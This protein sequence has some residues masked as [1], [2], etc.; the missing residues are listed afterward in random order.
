MIKTFKEIF[1]HVSNRR[2]IDFFLL[3]ILTIVV[4]A[5]EMLSIASVVPFIKV[6]TD[7]NFLEEKYL[8]LKFVTIRNKEEAIIITG[9][10]FASFFFINSLLRCTLIYITVKLANIVTAELSIKIYTASLAESYFEHISKQT[11]NII[12][13]VTQK[14]YQTYF[15]ISGIINLISSIFI[16]V[17]LISILIWI[18]P[19]VVLFSFIFLT[20]LYLIIVL[21]GKKILKKNSQ[22]INYEQNRIIFNLQNGL[23]AFR[24]IILDKNHK[25]FIDIFAKANLNKAK[26][27]AVNEIIQQSPRHILEAMGIVLVVVLIIFWNFFLG[28]SNTISNSDTIIEVFPT[29]AAL[30]LGAQKILPLINI[31]YQNFSIFKGNIYQVNEVLHTL[32]KYEEKQKSKRLVIEQKIE[33]NNLIS[34]TNVNFSYKDSKKNILEDINFEIKKGSKV[35]II[36]KSGEGKS[37]L[38]DLLMGL[39]EPKSGAIYIDGIKLTSTTISSWQSIISHVPQKLFLSNAS[40]LENIAFGKLTKDIDFQKVE[41]VSKKAQLHDFINNLSEGYYEQVGERG[42]KLSGGQI[43]RVGLARSLYKNSEIIIFDEATNS[44]DI[45]T[46]RLI[47]R[48]LYNL[49]KNLTLIIVAHRL[50]TLSHCDLIF[51]IK[52][53]K[54][55]KIKG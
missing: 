11:S 35:G 48:E 4:S 13:A 2:K 46:E 31:L 36:G 25:Y 7:V 33:F 45:E 42:I 5:F 53:K 3:L 18:N 23:G 10:I 21:L 43:Q 27:Q 12:S 32:T 28:N 14:V 55:I 51:E 15:T 6:A 30:T 17:G 19:R 34:F 47:M 54:I 49:D 22:I 20:F 9:L 16:L 8:I 29:L 44:L 37:T 39:L 40:F 24:D 26:S 52:K 50:D 41:T 38:L 1:L